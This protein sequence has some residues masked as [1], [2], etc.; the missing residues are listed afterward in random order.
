MELFAEDMGRVA[1]MCVTEK[2]AEFKGIAPKKVG[3]VEIAIVGK[4]RM[5]VSHNATMDELKRL[6]QDS[7]KRA[8]IKDAWV[9]VADSEFCQEFVECVHPYVTIVKS[10]EFKEDIEKYEHF[11]R[12]WN[13]EDA[14]GSY[15]HQKVLTVGT[16]ESVEVLFGE[17][18]ENPIGL[19]SIK[20]ITA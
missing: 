9:L 2:G 20:C 15:A 7:E 12:G 18:R 10:A 14:E 8:A 16:D 5:V 4:A 11:S 17:S 19:L 1:K 3:N 13:V 6:L